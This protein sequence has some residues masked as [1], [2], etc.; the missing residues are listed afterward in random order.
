MEESSEIHN[1]FRKNLK[2]L[3][4]TLGNASAVLSTA[5]QKRQT[6][7]INVAMYSMGRHIQI[8]VR[9]FNKGW[10]SPTRLFTVKERKSTF[11]EA[12]CSLG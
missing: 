4:K 8:E 2:F 1:G 3:L 7:K 5:I 12:S 9:S 10:K 6:S 11:K